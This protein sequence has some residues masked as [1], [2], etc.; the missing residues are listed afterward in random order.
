MKKFLLNVSKKNIPKIFLI[1]LVLLLMIL[2]SSAKTVYA[3]SGSSSNLYE[4]E[5]FNINSIYKEGNDIY[6]SITCKKRASSQ[7]ADHMS[8][9]SICLVAS[10]NHQRNYSL[11]LTNSSSAF[12]IYG[13]EEIYI[14]DDLLTGIADSVLNNRIYSISNLSNTYNLFD[15]SI[16]FSYIGTTTIKT[17]IA[18]SYIYFDTYPN[19]WFGEHNF[20]SI[21]FSLYVDGEGYINPSNVVNVQF[22]FKDKKEQWVYIDSTLDSL[23]E[24]YENWLVIDSH[25][26]IDLS[27]KGDAYY[28]NLS[29]PTPSTN[30]SSDFSAEMIGCDDGFNEPY[31]REHKMFRPDGVF[32][33]WP[34]GASDFK[35]VL[36]MHHCP[37]L[38][39][40]ASKSNDY[41]VDNFEVV[42][43][44]YYNYDGE[45][46]AASLYNTSQTGGNPIVKIHD[47]STGLDFPFW[48]NPETGELE[49]APGYYFDD[50]H[51]LRDPNGNRVG[52][53]ENNI[54]KAND[55]S[56]WWDKFLDGWG[57]F[58]TL[59]KRC[60][61]I[62][63][64][65]IGIIIVIKILSLIGN[66][67]GKKDNNVNINVRS[68]SNKSR[69]RRK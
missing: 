9:N 50:N 66:L 21:F 27:S 10:D 33:E 7:Y 68:G 36:L 44:D 56:N 42:Q 61:T 59:I 40:G 22:Q 48:L 63:L 29:D 60:I 49:L 31:Y 58:S 69:R 41:N 67:G 19:N 34:S 4:C 2:F 51:I 26:V 1:F 38:N 15:E 64:L 65:V 28:Y 39:T 55:D 53:D 5:D 54:S 8:F 25:E 46:V 17:A 14:I 13:G 12:Y 16:C 45:L 23:G 32:N 6:L 43:F 20:A 62:A 35:Y 52:A 18:Y 57:D 37:K 11:T 47:S 30:L 3:A 24:R